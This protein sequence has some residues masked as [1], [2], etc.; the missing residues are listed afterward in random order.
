MPK[1][2]QGFQKGNRLG[3]GQTYRLGKKN[4]LE[5]RLAISK[6]LKGK[7]PKNLALIN[8]NK[9]GSGNPMFGKKL[10]IE[11]KAKLQASL[12]KSL[13]EN[14]EI[15][16]KKRFLFTGI[17]NPKW[18]GGITRLEAQVRHCFQYRQWRSDIYT[19]DNYT[20]QICGLRKSNQLN[21]DHYP[22]S[23]A[24]IFHDNQIKTFEQALNCEEFWNINNGR[25]LCVD[26]HRKTPNYLNRK[27]VTLNI[28]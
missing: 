9:K 11:H 4:S 21:A 22:K 23:F 5:T 3:V 2:L 25:T 28:N 26:C 24:K 18:K 14:P 12:R 8:A 16:Q 17:N 27:S 13:K 1:G 20:C 7:I 19:R 6:A 10:T 15:I